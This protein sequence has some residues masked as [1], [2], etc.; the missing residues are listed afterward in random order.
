MLS[1]FRIFHGRF[2]FPRG[3]ERTPGFI[4]VVN[5]SVV[6]H[7]HTVRCRRKRTQ[8]DLDLLTA[9]CCASWPRLARVYIWYS[10]GELERF[11]EGRRDAGAQAPPPRSTTEVSSQLLYF[12][13]CIDFTSR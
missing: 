11:G 4:F 2:T 1:L 8:P 3:K 7:W 12:V 13:Y 6:T 5:A 9:E 10:G